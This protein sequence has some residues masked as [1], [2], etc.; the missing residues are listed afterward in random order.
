MQ[1]SEI[2][3][4]RAQISASVEVVLHGYWQPDDSA[5]LRA[6]VLADWCDELEAWPVESIR[7]ALRKHRKDFPNRRP[8]PGHILTLLNEA[9]GRRN[10]ETVRLA[11]AKPPE[12]ER[13][14][15]SPERRREI[16][17][18]TGAILGMFKRMPGATE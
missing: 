2:A 3:H 4:H 6:A 11:L 7:A 5:G 9:W 1:P 15:P 13:E 16:V 8:N 17:A 12:P 18:E 10:A 14:L